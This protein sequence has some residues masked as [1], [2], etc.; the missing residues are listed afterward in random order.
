MEYATRIIQFPLGIVGLAVS[1]AIL[2]TLS[3]FNDGRRES[4][5]GIAKRSCSASSWCCC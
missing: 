2:P 1:F 3:R 4:A 5:A